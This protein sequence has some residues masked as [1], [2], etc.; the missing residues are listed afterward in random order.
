VDHVIHP[1][2]VHATC[3]RVLLQVYDSFPF[4]GIVLDWVVMPA[5]P[6]M[7]LFNSLHIDSCG[8]ASARHRCFGRGGRAHLDLSQAGKEAHERLH[9]LSLGRFHDQE[10]AML[11]V[12]HRLRLYGDPI[13]GGGGRR[14]M[15][16]EES[17]RVG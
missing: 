11:S 3:H 13:P 10:E 14:D 8:A 17:A 7:H 5:L 12:N 1:V 16:Q 6:L 15:G 4:M 9:P 2:S